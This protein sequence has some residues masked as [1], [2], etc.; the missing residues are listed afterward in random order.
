MLKILFTLWFASFFSWHA[1]AQVKKPNKMKKHSAEATKQ[2]EK[3][4]HHFK[5]TKHSEMN[6]L[7]KT[8]KK[9]Y[10]HRSIA[11]NKINLANMSDDFKNIRQQILNLKS[12]DQ[13]AD[14]IDNLD[15]KIHQLQPDARFLGANLLLLKPFRGITYRLI[16]LASKQRITHSYLRNQ[17]KIMA[18]NMRIY[19]PI[20]HWEVAFKFITEPYQND[21]GKVVEQFTD[22]SSY[23]EKGKSSTEKFQEYLDTTVYN[24]FA[25]VANILSS[26]KISKPAVW[27]NR[28]T[29]GSQSFQDD[30][31]EAR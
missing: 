12:A 5:W 21:D 16:P 18:S 28:I 20:D 23:W 25:R 10:H 29:F 24:N 17:V 8:A 31:V 2:A 22:S 13:M 1:L 26:F 15:R 4:N 19:L 14:L 11:S 9:A 6:G 30:F 27:D 3:T 7:I